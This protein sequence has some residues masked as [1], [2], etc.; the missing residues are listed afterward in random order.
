MSVGFVTIRNILFPINPRNI[1]S[2][3]LLE[4]VATHDEGTDIFAKM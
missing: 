2:G 4:A 3:G 1:M